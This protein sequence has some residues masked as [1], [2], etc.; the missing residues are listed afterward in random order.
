MRYKTLIKIILVISSII[1]QVACRSSK[2]PH[3]GAFLKEGS[4]LIELLQ[5]EGP[6][7]ADQINN[8]P[9]AS[10]SNPTIMFWYPDIVLQYLF[11]VSNAGEGEEV[12][13]N[14][15]PEDDDLLEIQ[16]KQPLAPDIYCLVQT[17]PLGVFFFFPNWCFRIGGEQSSLDAT[18]ADLTIP[19]SIQAVEP[20]PAETEAIA[21]V[22]IIKPHEGISTDCHGY[23]NAGDREN[24]LKCYENEIWANPNSFSAYNHMARIYQLLDEWDLALKVGQ[25]SLTLAPTSMEEVATYVR[26]GVTYYNMRDYTSAIDSLLKGTQIDPLEPE[27]YVWLGRAYKANGQ[28]GESCNAYQ[29][30]L[31]IGEEQGYRW[32]IDN[33]QPGLKNC[34]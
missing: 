13:F 16:P 24:A 14:V 11:L 3:Y 8:I 10:N 19:T 15:V 1:A 26:I 4:Q 17:D 21:P 32:V 6:P 30:A 7:E 20:I 23:E 29:T 22:T 18:G 9:V 2:P 25:Y 33:A 31:S 27:L 28:I 12:G 5:F 34:P